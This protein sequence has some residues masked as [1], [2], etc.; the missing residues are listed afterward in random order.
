MSAIA[1][2]VSIE[3]SVCLS[4]TL[5]QS[6]NTTGWNKKLFVY[7][8]NCTRLHYYVRVLFKY[9]MTRIDA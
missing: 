3:R 7:M 4:V 2:D 9:F 1:T 6:A 8:P 5:L